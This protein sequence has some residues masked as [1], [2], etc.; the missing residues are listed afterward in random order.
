MS[1]RR[2]THDLFAHR[3]ARNIPWL[4]FCRSMAILLVLGS[5]TMDFGLERLGLK[6][7]NWGWTGVD[8]FF[9]LSGF[10]IAKQLWTELA[11]TRN[12]RIG[13][14]LLKRGLRIWP[15]YYAMI[16]IV[17]LLDLV[18]HKSPKPLLSDFFCIS[19]YFHNQVPGS[20]SLS[21]E[22]QFYL[23]LPLVLILLKSLPP[24]A[25]LAV[26]VG[27]L[28]ALPLIRH[29]M[30]PYLL[31]AGDADIVAHGFHMHTDGLAVGVI[32]A[33]MAVFSKGW[34]RSGRGRYGIPIVCIAVGLLEHK[35]HSLTLS[36]SSLGLLYGGIVMA[37]L[38]TK[39]PNRLTD[40]RGFH[41]LSRLS[42]GSY[43]NNLI[44]VH[45][46]DPLT[47]PFVA[48]HAGSTLFFVAWYAGFVLLS[49]A[50]A[51]ITY[52]YIE[53]PFLAL[54]ERWLASAQVPPSVPAPAIAV[55][56]RA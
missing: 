15:L 36:F 14:F 45:L 30:T 49:N 11:S 20:W 54:R 48:A 47:R 24:K 10:L 8:L 40:W 53:A 23:A 3:D 5:H 7:F 34:W 4:D 12:I 13:R 44:L 35:F 21:I 52:A 42:Y 9:V 51:L 22:E 38:R 19:D 37:G 2:A 46:L 39:L 29:V 6:Y 55:A 18:G 43:L 32:L 31:R 27:W 28:L 50:L 33:W 17:F 25:L 1:L 41:V 16:G 56:Q 26:P